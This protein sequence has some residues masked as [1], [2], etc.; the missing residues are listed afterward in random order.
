M[1]RQRDLILLSFPFSDLKSGKVRPVIVLSN[2]FYNKKSEDIIVVPVTTN[3]NLKEHAILFTNFD[4]ESGKL[5]KDSKI[6][7]DR[8]L[9]IS[10][11]LIRMKIG[12]VKKDIIEKIKEELLKLF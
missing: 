5:L 7:V 12:T 9:S 2:D 1:I 8:I 10:K 4:L 11:K 3:L 6:K